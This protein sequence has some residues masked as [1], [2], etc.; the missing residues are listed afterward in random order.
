MQDAAV[1]RLD[2]EV[3]AVEVVEP[4]DRALGGAEQ[5]ERVRLGP[6]GGLRERRGQRVGEGLAASS[7]WLRT[8]RRTSR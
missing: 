7:F 1:G 4:E 8:M 3:E 6:L 2:L 5:A